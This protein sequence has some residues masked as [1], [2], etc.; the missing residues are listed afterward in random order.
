MRLWIDD[1]RAAPEGWLWAKTSADAL[2]LL[3]EHGDRIEEVSF[4][5]DLGGDD[6]TMPVADWIAKMAWL[7]RMP[8]P[9]WSVHSANP[10]GRENLKRTLTRAEEFWASP[11]AFHNR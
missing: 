2:A 5:H 1:Y 8:P 11:C 10:V 3:Q 7:G 4:D 6:T 9:K